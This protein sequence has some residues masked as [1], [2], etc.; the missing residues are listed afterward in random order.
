MTTMDSSLDQHMRAWLA[1]ALDQS[2]RWRQS[3]AVDYPEDPRNAKSAAAL[4]RAAAYVR[5]KEGGG[6]H[7]M[8]E[9]VAACDETGYDFTSFGLPG[10][11]SQRLAGRYGFDH[12]PG[13]PDDASHD[14]L[15]RQIFVASLDDIRDAFD[16]WDDE[17]PPDSALGRLFAEHLP[18]RKVAPEPSIVELLTEIRDLL[19]DRLPDQN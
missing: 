7:L 3:K 5:Q 15:L 1:E 2:A 6:I 4:A 14:A 13:L 18:Q 8:R 17:V 11:E 10:E 12:D 16:N 9:L 19:R